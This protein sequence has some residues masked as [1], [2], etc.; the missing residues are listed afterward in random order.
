MSHSSESNRYVKDPGLLVDLCRDVIDQLDAGNDFAETVSMETQL[1]EISKA[2]EKLKKAGVSVPDPLRAE[3]TR[4][5][6][7][8]GIQAEGMQALNHLADELDGILKDL[9]SRLG[10]DVISTV[11]KSRVKR[12]KLPKT[13]KDV[14]REQII[15]ALKKL[16]GRAKVS[17]VL[18]EIEKQLTGKLLPGDIEVRQD[19]KTL[20]WRNN[21]QWERLRMVRD[22]TLCNDSPNG[23]WELSE[24]HI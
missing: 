14:L 4:L 22:G 1:R 23:V 8:L 21:T 13:G 16:G 2:V 19:G 7:A 15:R 3:K 9:K 18:D 24:E 5:V 10:R 12:S 6:A 11:R 17:E 20:A